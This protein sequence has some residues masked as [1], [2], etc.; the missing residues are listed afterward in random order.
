MRELVLGEAERPQDDPA[1]QRAHDDLV[2]VI[3][4]NMSWYV[5][6]PHVDGLFLAV[7]RTL[8][9]HVVRHWYDTMDGGE[10]HVD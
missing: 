1:T 5:E 6:W 9:G 8:P 4:E 7:F 10:P 2:R 3:Q